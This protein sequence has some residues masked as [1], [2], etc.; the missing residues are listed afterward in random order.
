MKYL[1]STI[2]LL[3]SQFI[4]DSCASANRDHVIK[5]ETTET[6]K[7]SDLKEQAKRCVCAQIWLPV[8]GTDNKTYSNACSANCAGVKFKAGNCLLE[9]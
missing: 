2:V 1:L 4:L 7:Q 5:K 6:A 8:C 3:F 9:K